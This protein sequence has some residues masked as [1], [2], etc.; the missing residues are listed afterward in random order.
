MANLIEIKASSVVLEDIKMKHVSIE[1]LVRSY[2]CGATNSDDV[3]TS[4]CNEFENWVS[5]CVVW[6]L[7]SCR[8][9]LSPILPV[10]VR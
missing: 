9:I 4:I 2:H 5:S 6:V 1:R 10:A 8:S 3:F 7:L